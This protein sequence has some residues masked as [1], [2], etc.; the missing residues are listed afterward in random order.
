MVNKKTTEP[1]YIE[2]GFEIIEGS[3]R[4]TCFNNPEFVFDMKSMQE[5]CH[6]DDLYS[7]Y[8]DTVNHY[9][10]RLTGKVYPSYLLITNIMDSG[11]NIGC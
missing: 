2:S 8:E 7:L 6:G 11:W 9:H 3:W 1:Y 5:V 10:K 4:L